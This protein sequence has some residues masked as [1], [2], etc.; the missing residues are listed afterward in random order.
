MTN[1]IDYRVI[2]TAMKQSRVERAVAFR[3]MIGGIA[4]GFR[5]TARTLVAM[6]G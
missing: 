5:R 2:D 3:S 1:H 6:F 4:Q